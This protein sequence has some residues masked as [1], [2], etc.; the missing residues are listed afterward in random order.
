LIKQQASSSSHKINGLGV[1]LLLLLFAFLSPTIYIALIIKITIYASSR[2]AHNNPAFCL[3]RI[4]INKLS[5]QLTIHED[6]KLHI[7][8]VKLITIVLSPPPTHSSSSSFS[9]EGKK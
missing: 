9:Q 6:Y 1:L 3:A 7:M 4:F 8:I 2:C 5:F